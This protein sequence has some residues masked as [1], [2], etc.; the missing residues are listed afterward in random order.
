MMPV[1]VPT[2]MVTEF[3]SWEA[4][5]PNIVLSSRMVWSCPSFVLRT[6]GRTHKRKID[7]EKGRTSVKGQKMEL[8]REKPL[9]K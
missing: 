3:A 1:M 6:R 5:D 4:M 9:G 8:I 7:K 2:V